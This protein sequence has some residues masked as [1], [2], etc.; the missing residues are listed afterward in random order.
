MARDRAERGE[1]GGL[2]ATRPGPSQPRLPESTSPAEN[3]ERDVHAIPDP[4]SNVLSAEPGVGKTCTLR[5]LR[6]R[7]PETEYRLTYCHNATLG[8]RDFYRQLC[9]ALGLSPRAT[10]A[11]VFHSV[12]SHV[13]ELGRQRVHPVFLLDEA[14]L[15]QQQ[16]LEHLHV[17]A[18]YQWDQK[19]LM[20]MVLVGL[21]ELWGQLSL[22][23]NRSL[24]SRINCRLSIESPSVADTT[25]Y[26]EHRLRRAGADKLLL[27]SDALTILH[28]ATH[29]QLRDIDRIATNALR[30]A[31]RRKQSMV[32]RE[33][34]EGVLERDQQPRCES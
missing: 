21:P 16:V 33:L 2:F 7:L 30:T 25:E 15:L 1:V 5:A 10:A 6:R 13:E 17:L 18:N 32:D 9:L 26:V 14:H 34:L 24:W 4:P 29:G 31:A 12:S 23:K 19:P 8:R 11:A 20:S 28:E 22:R 3:K 27:G